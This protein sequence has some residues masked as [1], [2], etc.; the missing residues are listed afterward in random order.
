MNYLS[1][2]PSERPLVSR[3]VSGSPVTAIGCDNAPDEAVYCE[4]AANMRW[5]RDIDRPLSMDRGRFL[6]PSMTKTIFNNRKDRRT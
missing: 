2:Q 6:L 3:S 4:V 1:E 5:Y